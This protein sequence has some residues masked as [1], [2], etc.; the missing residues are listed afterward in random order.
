MLPPDPALEAPFQ[1]NKVPMA[2]YCLSF[3]ILF[4]LLSIGLLNL[5]PDPDEVRR[6]HE[7]RKE[8]F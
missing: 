5:A 6:Q 3:G 7:E 2:A 1:P 8:Y 4:L